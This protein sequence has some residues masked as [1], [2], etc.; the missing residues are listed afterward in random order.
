M[1]ANEASA[2]LIEFTGFDQKPR[3]T[4]YQYDSLK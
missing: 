4:I 3:G 2:A 1:T